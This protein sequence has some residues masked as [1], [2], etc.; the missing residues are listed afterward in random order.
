MKK[1]IKNVSTNIFAVRYCGPTIHYIDEQYDTGRI[2]AQKSC[3]CVLEWL[4]REP[5]CKIS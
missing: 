4:S 3:S 1:C 2:L 5:G